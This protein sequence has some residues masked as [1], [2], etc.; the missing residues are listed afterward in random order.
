MVTRHAAC[1]C[2]QLHLVCDGEPKR[3]SMCH[4]LECQRRSGSV[5][6]VQAWFGEEQVVSVVGISKPFTRISDAGRSL[7]FHFCPTCGS[8]L[9]WKAE[10]FPALVAVAVGTFADPSFPSPSFSVWERRR[11]DWIDDV[12]SD[13]TIQHSK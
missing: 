3:I 8:T 13:M 12:P 1:N 7:T 5:F 9:F 6:G 4:C 2:G 10:A 11:H